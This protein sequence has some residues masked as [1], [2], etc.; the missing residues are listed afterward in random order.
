M[1]RFSLKKGP[2]HEIACGGAAYVLAAKSC[3][4]GPELQEIAWHLP[5]S[6]FRSGLAPVSY[7]EHL[8]GYSD[9]PEHAAH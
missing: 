4:T 8:H 5:Q 1:Q 9:E 6:F 3:E 7:I 2:I